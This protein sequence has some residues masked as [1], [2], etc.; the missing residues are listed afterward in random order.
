[1]ARGISL[2]DESIIAPRLRK[3]QREKIIFNKLNGADTIVLGN[4][5]LSNFTLEHIKEIKNVNKI[6][7][8]V[9]VDFFMI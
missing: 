2:N 9:A 5:R 4:I 7:L 1:M 6:K 3:D 8:S